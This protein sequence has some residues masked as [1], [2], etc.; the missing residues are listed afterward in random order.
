MT[1]ARKRRNTT[2]LEPHAGAF[3]TD[4]H[5]VHNPPGLQARFQR[6]GGQQ[7][8]GDGLV[9]APDELARLALIHQAAMAC[10]LLLA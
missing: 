6:L 9:Y 7:V 2:Q 4:I 3:L 10:L 5:D 1:S 8:L